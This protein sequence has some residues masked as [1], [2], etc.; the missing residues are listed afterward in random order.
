MLD[1]TLI[2]LHNS[3]VS[4]AAKLLEYFLLSSHSIT[5]ARFDVRDDLGLLDIG[6]PLRLLAFIFG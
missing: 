6:T 3:L 1:N 4:V 5:L 2:G